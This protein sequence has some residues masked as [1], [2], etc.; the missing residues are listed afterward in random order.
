MVHYKNLLLIKN[1]QFINYNLFSLIDTENVNVIIVNSIFNGNQNILIASY[2]GNGSNKSTT[3]AIK[4]TQFNCDYLNNTKLDYLI[5]SRNVDVIIVNCSFNG[6][7]KILD[8]YGYGNDIRIINCNF[9]GSLRALQAVGHPNN[10]LKVTIIIK[11]SQFINSVLKDHNNLLMLLY[12][13]LMLEGVVIF[14]TITNHSSIIEVH[15]R[16]TITIHGR[17]EFSN[18]IG[19]HLISFTE[20]DSVFKSAVASIQYIKIK[21]PTIISIHHNQL[22]NYF[23]LSTCEGTLYQ[24][25]IFQYYTNRTFEDGNF[26]IEYYNNQLTV[27]KWSCN[28]CYIPVTNCQ[29]LPES[30]F[31]HMIPTEVNNRFIKHVNNSDT[32]KMNIDQD[33]FCACNNQM[34]RD[35]TI[36]DLGYLY[37]GETLNIFLYHKNITSA[38]H[39]T[40][41]IVKN[42]INIP[43]T[44]LC[45]VLSFAEHSQIITNNHCSKVSYSSLIFWLGNWCELFLKTKSI[46]GDHYK[47]F[48][49]RKLNCPPGFIEINRTCQCD[50]IIVDYGIT[51]CNINNQTVLRPRNTWITATYHIPY[52]YYIS[53]QCRF[54]YCLPQSSHLNFS[55]PNSQ[56]QFNRSGLL[57]GHCQQGLST[58]FSTSQCQHCS[59]VYLF[60][61]VPIAIAG[62]ILVIVLFFLNTTVTDGTI[63]GFILFANIISIN[64]S[65]VFSQIDDF[66][67]T[68]TFISLANLDL[69]IQTC[70]YNGM[71]DYAKMWLQ[72]AFPFYLIFIATLIIITSRYSTT[73]QR[74]TARRAL[75]VLATLFLLSYTKILRIVSNVLFF[76]STITHL[77]S[78]HTTLVWSVDANVPLFGVRF[79]I[80]FIVCL[81][82]FLILIPFNIILLFTRTLSRFRFINRFKPIL[83]AYQGPYKD[84]FYYWTGLQLVVRAV[85]LAISSLDR[86]NNLTI[87]I[88][89]LSILGGIHGIVQ[90]LKSKIQNY[91]EMLL[92]FYLHALYVISLN[93]QDATDV[94]I[95]NII[96]FLAAVQFC[97]IIMYHIITYACGANNLSNKLRAGTNCNTFTKWICRLL[98]TPQCQEFQLQDF[99]RDNIPEVAFNYCEYREPLIG[100]D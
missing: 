22:C 28:S 5:K 93:S 71:D 57:C 80:L 35:C 49:V 19:G 15:D 85:L 55:T 69:G 9:S 11:N 50:P 30:A 95:T 74:L 33:T 79:T 87:S 3:V 53:Q 60:L 2:R 7:L 17:V 1:T 51:K 67:P 100:Q 24:F 58:V 75:P 40:E 25:C 8:L 56:C 73:I 42:D 78:K 20:S 70:F 27:S 76:Y 32:I 99:S 81:I 92:M 48:Y 86:N 63:N 98:N 65:L 84:R 52:S 61:I 26:S 62:L 31:H 54:Y 64:T 66:T 72:L 77:P 12:S 94:I 46:S 90:P 96:I 97:F 59:N 16:S 10:L 44:W 4:N 82:L 41:I 39:V 47:R 43:G 38:H 89:I 68:Y 18:N 88:I 6:G 14:H 13:N 83:D 21:D 23:A 34:N 45:I 36:N 29:W 37:P 91:Q